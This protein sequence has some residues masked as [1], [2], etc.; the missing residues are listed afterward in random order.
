MSKNFKYVQKTITV[1]TAPNSFGTRVPLPGNAVSATIINT[2]T[3]YGVE[4]RVGGLGPWQWVGK[5]AGLSL[6]DTANQGISL[7]LTNDG[8][9]SV[10]V[11]VS[12]QIP[13][14]ATPKTEPRAASSVLF[15][16]DSI[17]FAG[18]ILPNIP[19]QLG[20]RTATPAYTNLNSGG[21]F[22]I[23]T[24]LSQATPTGA[25][26]T[27]RFYAATSSITFQ[28]AGDAEG[29]PVPVSSAAMM[30]AVPSANPD[31]VCYLGTLPRNKPTADKADT[32]TNIGSTLAHVSDR[33]T[34]G[35]VGWAQTL[36]GAPFTNATTFA[37]D[38]ARSTDVLAARAQWENIVSDVT[39]IFLGTN[40]V[41]NDAD[42]TLVRGKALT[43][44]AALETIV[45]MRQALGSAVVVG[46]LLPHDVRETVTIQAAAE[47]NLG[48]REMADRMGFRVW[49]AGPYVT[50]ASGLWV[51]AYT[52]DGLH[53]SGIGAYVIAKRA[54]A[55]AVQELVRKYSPPVPALAVADVTN[56]PYGNL[57]P[58]PGMTGSAAPGDAGASG[59]QPTSWRVAR[60]A[61]SNI[62]AVCTAPDAGGAEA[63]PDGRPGKYF[64]VAIS[65]PGAGVEAMR[66]RTQVAVPPGTAYVAGDYFVFEGEFLISGTGI[67]TFYVQFTTSG[68][69]GV[70]S[71]ALTEDPTT[72]IANLDGDTV[73]VVFRSKPVK[74]D[75]T[76]GIL[77]GIAVS[78]LA[79]GAATIKI[80]Q[81]ALNVHKVP[82]P[83]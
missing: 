25:G 56:A 12:V 40:D 20:V 57:L 44:L 2:D 50:Q 59:T 76:T 53:P 7:R 70:V 30:Y 36:L 75:G 1:T 65:N 77:P 62:V 5:G 51:P 4:C 45:A 17:T 79:G 81:G 10:R 78:L 13:V 33:S 72:N 48:V 69:P 6:T 74:L 61:G 83:A 3:T 54:I 37:V 23:R 9:E 19:T 38:G 31:Y 26:S 55:P 64:T 46:S 8:G 15:L 66:I 49:D 34:F 32:I 35:I 71:F 80:P 39:H 29:P 63:L 43:A 21:Q 52:K 82:A 41:V 28:A 18:Q 73:R 11:D 60:D 24:Y 14:G 16:G 22:I 47:F 67:R 58:N 42:P 27:L 68:G